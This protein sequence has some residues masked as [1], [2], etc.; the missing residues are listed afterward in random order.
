MLQAEAIICPRRLAQKCADL[1]QVQSPDYTGPFIK[2]EE[3]E[4][5]PNPAHVTNDRVISEAAHFS[6]M[7][8]EKLKL[9]LRM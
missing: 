6:Q 3:M 9:S 2:L 7:R 1:F 4:K 5:A 8:S